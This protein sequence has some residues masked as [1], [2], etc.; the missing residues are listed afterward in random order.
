MIKLIATDLDGTLLHDDKSLPSGFPALANELKKRGIIFVAASGRQYANVYNTLLPY[1]EDF[2]IISDNGSINGKGKTVTSSYLM[3]P[4]K[5]DEILVG[6]EGVDGAL[7]L[8]CTAECGYYTNDDPVFIREMHRYYVKVANVGDKN[9]EPLTALRIRAEREDLI[10]KSASKI[11]VFCNGKANEINEKMPNIDGLKHFVSGADW[12][13]FARTDVSK[14]TALA[15]LLAELRVAPSDCLAFG[16][17]FNDREML[18]LCGLSFVTANASEGMRKLFPV[19]KSNND[20]GVTE[21][22]LSLI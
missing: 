18:E 15:A 12:V 16:D 4:D 19:I 1:S 2:Y 13:D 10:G 8:I 20:D 9:V 5:V 11:A 17:Q 7:P 3:P 21:K 22:I 6:L 14:G